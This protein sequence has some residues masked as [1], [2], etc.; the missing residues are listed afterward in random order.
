MTNGFR[1]IFSALK[2][3]LAPYSPLLTAKVDFPTHYELCSVKEVLIAGCRKHEISFA[4][5]NL[6]K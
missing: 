2:A 3:L 4:A 5:G 6:Q 1:E